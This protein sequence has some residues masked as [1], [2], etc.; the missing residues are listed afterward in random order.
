MMKK[1]I[2]FLLT[3]AMLCLPLLGLAETLELPDTYEALRAMMPDLPDSE[4]ENVALRFPYFEEDSDGSIEFYCDPAQWMAATGNAGGHGLSFVYDEQLG[5]YVYA[6]EQS[7]M[8]FSMAIASGTGVGGIAV[9]SRDE[10]DWVRNFV[11]YFDEDASAQLCWESPD[12]WK[13]DSMTDRSGAN[14]LVPCLRL[15]KHLDESSILEVNRYAD[16]TEA[17]LYDNDFNVLQQQTYPEY[18]E[19]CAQFAPLAPGEEFAR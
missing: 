16:R 15:Q 12:T 8:M 6:D 19:F 7:K 1:A 5:A 2:S 11:V 13:W 4:P 18:S 3:L 17:I 14:Y 9:G 10:N